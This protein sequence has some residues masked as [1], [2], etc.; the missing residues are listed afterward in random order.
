MSDPKSTTP[1]TNGALLAAAQ[2][3]LQSTQQAAPQPASNSA[4][5][6]APAA[7]PKIEG[8]FCHNPNSTFV[9]PDGT[10]L[11]FAGHT[12]HTNK[13]EE[14]AELS[15]VCGSSPI[16]RIEDSVLAS[17]NE[18]LM[19]QITGQLQADAARAQDELRKEAQARAQGLAQ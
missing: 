14:I 5:P 8:F 7:A 4:A 16:C 18:R 15:K 10:V 9:M 17:E 1:A 12:Y 19:T 11:R 6:A 2:A 3:A 13:P